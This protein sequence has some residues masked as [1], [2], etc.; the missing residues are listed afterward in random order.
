M[1]S[2]WAKWWTAETATPPGPV[3][4][5]AVK[6]PVTPCSSGA[7]LRVDHDQSPSVPGEKRTR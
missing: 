4:G 7:A 5:P 2:A 6:V 3:R 1:P